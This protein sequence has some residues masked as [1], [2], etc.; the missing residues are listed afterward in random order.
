GASRGGPIGYGLLKKGSLP[1]KRASGL[2]LTNVAKVA[3]SSLMVL[4]LRTWICRPIVRAAAPTSLTVVSVYSAS[5]GL[6]ITATR[7]AAGTSSRR[8]SSRFAVTSVLKKLIPV[9]LPS[10]R[11]RLATRPSL[12]GSGPTTKTTGIDVVAAFAANAGLT[13]LVAAITA[14]CRRTKSAARVE[15]ARTTAS[16]VIL[17]PARQRSAHAGLPDRRRSARD[18]DRRGRGRSRLEG[19]APAD[20][21]LA[22]ARDQDANGLPALR[23]LPRSAPLDW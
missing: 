22:S 16:V 6:I 4:A 15:G 8:S 18:L 3:L 21:A 14:T 17:L 10:G 12:T 7:V 9:R 1:T 2:S 19:R 23:S 20:R 5:A 13:P 11:A